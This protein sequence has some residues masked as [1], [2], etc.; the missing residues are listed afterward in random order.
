MPAQ[1]L[2]DLTTTCGLLIEAASYLQRGMHDDVERATGLSGAWLEVLLRLHRTPGGAMRINEVAA[3]V[4]L[5]AS[6]FS[7]L[8][9]R[10]EED[11]LVERHPDPRH[12]RATLLHITSAGEQRFAE[13]WKAL[14]PSQQ[15]RLGRLLSSDELDIL[16]TIT[17]KIRDANARPLVSSGRQPIV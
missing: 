12:R 7:R 4:T 9:D 6:S 2:R 8:A 17:R 10:M 14:E 5:A 3:Q 15:A 16:E 11:G 1:R 13:A